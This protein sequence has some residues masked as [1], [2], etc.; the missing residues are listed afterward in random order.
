[1]NAVEQG[2]EI[3]KTLATEGVGGLWKWIV[4]KLSD[5]KDTVMDAIQD[6]VVVKIVKAG[7]TWLISALNPAA[8]FIKACKM[9]YDVVMFFVEKG[10]QIKEFVDSVLDSVESIVSGGVGKVAQLI[11]NTLAK[12]LPLLLGF[13]ASL[14]GLGGI[15]EKIKEI[16]EK[17]QKPV[18]KV[19]DAVIKGALKLA[20]PIIRGVKGL[21]AKG[22]AAV[23][24][25]KAWVKG[26][27]KG[28]ESAN[29]AL[30]KQKVAEEVRKLSG[31][32]FANRDEVTAALSAIHARFRVDGL[33][34][35][36][37]V[38]DKGNLGQ[39]TVVA[40][41]SPGDPVGT[42][43]NT[44]EAAS[45]S[46]VYLELD[47][48]SPV[49]HAIA[50]FPDKTKHYQNDPGALHAEIKFIKDL[51]GT[52]L[53]DYE[54]GERV[55]ITLNINRTPCPDCATALSAS[56]RTGFRGRKIDLTVNATNIYGTTVTQTRPTEQ[57][58]ERIRVPVPRTS[59]EAL[60][61]MKH[62]GIKLGTWDIWTAIRDA[63]VANDPRAANLDRDIIEDNIA[64]ASALQGYISG[65]QEWH[66]AKVR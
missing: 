60:G 44:M 13:L 43:L 3:F 58:S 59:L 28:P 10:Q 47:V 50:V 54:F 63:V 64:R 2:V 34:S 42:L 23:A 25:G 48:Y 14:L 57:G 40:E 49:T 9:I 8:A 45:L 56:A 46:E 22:K 30:V 32:K 41:A 17:V 53:K 33:K 21:V 24:K 19:V 65:V 20:G 11:E 12:I 16:L 62:A 15:G 37:V 4:D 61:R 1:M 7:I 6:F 26:K 5:L 35:L 31:R 36:E 38:G 39:L 66:G 18:M 29:S 27:L 52:A 51:E 55:P